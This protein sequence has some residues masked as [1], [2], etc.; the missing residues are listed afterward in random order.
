MD[1]WVSRTFL[2]QDLGGVCCEGVKEEDENHSRDD[3]SNC[4]NGEQG[5]HAVSRDFCNHEYHYQLPRPWFVLDFKERVSWIIA[6]EL[7]DCLPK[8]SP[9]GSLR[10]K[11]A[12]H[13]RPVHLIV[14]LLE[15]AIYLSMRL[16]ILLHCDLGL[17]A[18]CVGAARELV[19]P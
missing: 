19:A 3:P 16:A 2:D 6:L 14:D 4:Q 11:V 5:E 13:D 9:V 15:I 12:V 17:L 10:V 7:Q 18:N 1:L 8:V